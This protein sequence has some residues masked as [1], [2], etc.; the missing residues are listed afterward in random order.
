M[1]NLILQ[2]CEKYNKNIK[3]SRKKQEF[4]KKAK[5]FNSSSVKS[6]NI[7]MLLQGLYSLAKWTNKEWSHD[8]IKELI[9]EESIDCKTEMIDELL[10]IILTKEL[11]VKKHGIKKGNYV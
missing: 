5:K 3:S 6:E 8:Q 11:Y 9:K 2:D 1:E 4:Q 7:F 10:D